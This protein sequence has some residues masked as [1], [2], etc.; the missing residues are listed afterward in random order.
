[1]AY[2]RSDTQP[3]VDSYDS[4]GGVVHPASNYI[5]SEIPG[6]WKL[7]GETLGPGEKIFGS[8][9][10]LAQ[11]EATKKRGQDP[12]S[13]HFNAALAAAY[14]RLHPNV[15]TEFLS[16]GEA[17]LNRD[18]NPDIAALAGMPVKR[19]WD[20][21]PPPAAP[22]VAAPG[23]SG[24]LPPGPVVDAP[25]ATYPQGGPPPAAPAAPPTGPVD[26]ANLLAKTGS[27]P[28]MSIPQV[29]QTFIRLAALQRLASQ[30][31]HPTGGGQQ[32]GGGPVL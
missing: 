22:P 7:S 21:G 14:S 2:V 6:V 9:A 16:A 29:D 10:E 27:V 15:G 1:M 24:P 25:V 31:A 5:P 12:N 13:P 3:K 32:L 26:I 23:G 30:M 17:G 18:F 11:H 20:Y 28:T 19:G 8:V 4:W